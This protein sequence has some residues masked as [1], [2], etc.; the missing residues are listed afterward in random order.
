M[1]SVRPDIRSF[2]EHYED[3]DEGALARCFCDTFLSLDP[4]VVTAL[5]PQALLAALPRRKALFHAVGSDGL[6]LADITEVPLD[7]IHTLVRT[8]WK[9]LMNTE[10][11]RDDITLRST[12]VLRQNGAWRIALY[13][14]HQNMP[15][16]FGD[17]AA[18]A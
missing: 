6:K 8:E 9:L 13:L 15:R 3:A 18:Q 16:L 7:D 12:F 11:R 4:N 17:L 14:N 1:P 2:F 10:R 5:T